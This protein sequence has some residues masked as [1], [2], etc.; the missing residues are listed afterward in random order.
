MLRAIPCRQ[1]RIMGVAYDLVTILNQLF[2]SEVGPKWDSRLNVKSLRL[3]T[4]N[5]RALE[6]TLLNVVEVSVHQMDTLLACCSL[7]AK[8]ENGLSGREIEEF[9][10]FGANKAEG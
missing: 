1:L 7:T 3:V 9:L 6:M 8:Q 2:N 5:Q 10:T 4:L